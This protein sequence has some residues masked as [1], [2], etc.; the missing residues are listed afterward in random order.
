MKLKYSILCVIS[1]LLFAIA[2]I[3]W[4]LY[5]N[6]YGNEFLLMGFILITA[7]LNVYFFI[8][9]DKEKKESRS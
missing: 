9:L 3:V 5:R 1:S 7:I 2:M 8:K 4:S 6:T